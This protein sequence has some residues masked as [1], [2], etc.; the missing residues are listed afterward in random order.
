MKGLVRITSA[1]ELES[2][3]QSDPLASRRRLDICLLCGIK[4]VYIALVVL[5]VMKFHDLSGDVRL[6]CLYMSIRGRQ[7]D[8][9]R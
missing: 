1:I 6:Q 8:G 5:G 2:S 7:H 3:L 9:K 4:A